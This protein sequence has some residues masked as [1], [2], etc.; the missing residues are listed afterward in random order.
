MRMCEEIFS[1]ESIRALKQKFR[2]NPHLLIQ[3]LTNILVTPLNAN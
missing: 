1:I 3:L 2:E